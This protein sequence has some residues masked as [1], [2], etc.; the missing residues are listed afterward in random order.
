MVEQMIADFTRYC[1]KYPDMK[2]E[3]VFNRYMDLLS[4]QQ[5][6]ELTPYFMLMMRTGEAAR[7]ADE[8]VKA[9]FFKPS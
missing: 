8:Q 6:T 1:L 7:E 2:I 9:L 5:I 3:S 4:P